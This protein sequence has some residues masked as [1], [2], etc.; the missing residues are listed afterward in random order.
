M[1][2]LIRR[3]G[4][5]ECQKCAC[6]VLASAIDVDHVIPLARGGQDVDSNIQAL[7]RPCHKLKTR[8]DFNFAKPPF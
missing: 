3:A 1:R 2:K 6:R 7:C 5:A 8:S 4:A